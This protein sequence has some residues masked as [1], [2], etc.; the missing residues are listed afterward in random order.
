MI[1]ESN[2]VFSIFTGAKPVSKAPALNIDVFPNPSYGSF[3][4]RYMNN[5]THKPADVNLIDISGKTLRK[6]HWNGQETTI[7]SP[8]LP[9]GLYVLQFNAGTDIEIKKL[10]VQ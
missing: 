9:K 3:S 8:G 5:T 6:F 7:A 4:I 10:M 1:T 2:Q